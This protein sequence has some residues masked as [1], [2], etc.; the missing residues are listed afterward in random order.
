[1]TAKELRTYLKAWIT[2]VLITEGGETGLQIIA[3]N[4]NAPVPSVPHITMSY[5]PNRTRIGRPSKGDITDE[6]TRKLVSDYEITVEIRETGGEG[7]RLITLLES[8]DR[9]D[10]HWAHFV[11]NKIS[12]YGEGEVLPVPRLRDENWIQESVVELRLGI[13]EGVTETTG[14]IDTVEYTGNVGGLQE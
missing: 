3:S 12:V 8:L 1:M 2:Q 5:A 10:I 7:D 14:W 9:E 6:G 11:N 4:P 13:A